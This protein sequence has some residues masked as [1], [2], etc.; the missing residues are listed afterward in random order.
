MIRLIL[1]TDFTEAFPHNLLRGILRYAKEQSHEPWV[2][3]RMPPS[4][5]DK[6]GIEGVLEWA[7]NWGANAIIGRFEN[8]D[9]VSIF[10]KNNIVALAQDFKQRFS[11]IPNITSDYI[12]TGDMAANFFLE[13]G[14]HNFAFYGYHNTVWSDERCAGFSHCINMAGYG[15]NFHSYKNLQL[16]TLWFY[17]T[18]SLVDWLKS[19]P[20]R[21]ALFCCDD[22]QGN[23]I[24]EVCNFSN[25]RIP[26]DIAVLGVDNDVTICNLSDPTLSSVNLDIERG[27]YDAASLIT[28]M[29]RDPDLPSEDVVIQ[30]TTIV[31]RASSNIY[32]TDDPYVLKSLEYIH[33]NLYVPLSV[34]DVLRQLPLS[35]RLF[36]IRFKR[37]IGQSIYSYI[38]GCRMEL[39]A[40]LLHD[41]NK[42]VC[43][44]AID[45]GINNYGNL[46]RQFRAVMGCTPTEYRTRHK[47]R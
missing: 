3:C 27:G 29:M 34:P 42:P 17:D 39:F 23:K 18:S 21:T 11:G 43:D 10:R 40:R 19:L 37:V 44:I 45:L 2:A 8:D 31:N 35:R 1:L 28:R 4:F 16:D 32:A 22:N 9:D 36:E 6:Y 14:F 5:K 33:N 25:I 46:I 30:P 47:T 26:E 15:D 41:S 38:S 20:P 7:R 12:K 13:K 24:T